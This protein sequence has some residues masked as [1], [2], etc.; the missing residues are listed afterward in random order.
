MNQYTSV[1]ESK[2]PVYPCH[3]APT[4]SHDHLTPSQELNDTGI[5]QCKHLCTAFPFHSKI[6]L[7]VASPL[8]R[9]IQTALIG[10]EPYVKQGKKILLLPDLQEVSDLPMDVGSS[11]AELEK[12]FGDV[13]DYSSMY[14]GWHEPKG[15]HAPDTEILLKR[16]GRIR[17]WLKGREERN[18]VAVFHGSFV[19][20]V[21]GN[22]KDGEKVGE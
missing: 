21:T 17:R 20:Y 22:I 2:T 4:Q 6:D 15:R 19:H 16:G 18:I 5:A 9:A 11:Q 10:Y 1:K 8:R 13:L 14:D 12:Q 3:R 7:I